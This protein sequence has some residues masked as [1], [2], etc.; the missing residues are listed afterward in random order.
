MNWIVRFYIDWEQRQLNRMIAALKATLILASLFLALGCGPNISDKMYYSGPDRESDIVFY[1]KKNTTND[2]VND[3]LNNKLSDPDPRPGGH[4][5]KPGVADTFL[6]RTQD[7]E[8]YAITLTADVTDEQRQTIL[9]VLNESP[10][11]Y[12]V[13]ENVTPNEI[14]LDPEKAAKEKEELEKAKSQNQPA[15]QMIVT[16]KSENR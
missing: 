2:Q 8:G 7:F 6:V 14:V 1:F 12:K 3:F 16:N 10:L 11:I 9:R 15:K 5:P 13:F 4:W